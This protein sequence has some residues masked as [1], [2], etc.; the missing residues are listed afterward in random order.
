VRLALKQ[1][2]T[3]LVRHGIDVLVL[4]CTH[5]PV[6]KETIVQLVGPQ[7]RVIDSAEQCAQDVGRRLRARGLLAD[8]E[9]RRGILRSYVTDDPAR[10]LKLATRFLGHE[11][12]LPTW[13]APDELYREQRS[14]PVPVSIPA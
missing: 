1:Y 10:F 11:I 14:G 3:P 6:L 4:G 13:V 9:T 5:Y 8:P 2:L 7:I 12:E